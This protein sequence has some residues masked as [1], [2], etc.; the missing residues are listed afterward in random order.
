M[1]KIITSASL[2][3]LGALGLQ[4]G[5]PLDRSYYAPNPELTPQQSTK[6]W[7]VSAT[8]RGF[9]DDNYNT[10]PANFRYLDPNTGLVT[11]TTPRSS[12]GFE[13]SPSIGIN[14]PLEGTF[15]GLNYTYSLRYYEDREDHNSD[16][17]HQADLR[18]THAFT[19][20]FKVDFKDSFVDTQEPQIVDL[21]NSTPLLRRSNSD[22]V[23]NH[24]SIDFNAQISRLFSISFGYENTFYDYEDEGDGSYSALL[25]RT[26]HLAKLDFQWHVQP[27]TIAHLG[28]QYGL[29]NYNRKD[30]LVPPIGGVPVPYVPGSPTDPETRN[31]RSHYIFVGADQTFTSQLLASVRLGVQ[32][33]DFPNAVAIDA[34]SPSGYRDD[35]NSDVSPYADASLTYTYAEGSF[36]QLGIRHARNQTDLAFVPGTSTAIMDQTST[37]VYGIITHRI[38]PKITGNLMGQIQISDFAGTQSSGDTDMLYIIG[39]NFNYQFNP[40][41]SAELGYNYDRLDSDVVYAD[42]NSRSF[43]RNR[44]Y[45]GLKASY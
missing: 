45:I 13:V 42:G 39:L 32:I 41:L 9:Y 11:T 14:I 1:K 7:S 19:D 26:E 20:T 25:D 30:S 28:Y 16:M 21:V 8:L 35:S 43:T 15:I 12:F 6:W 40:F 29:I 5:T 38:T 24:G 36:A 33:T 4:A 18:V 10:S 3:A 37:T 22:V 23:R 27:S 34:T 17:T 44:V 2:A 31:N